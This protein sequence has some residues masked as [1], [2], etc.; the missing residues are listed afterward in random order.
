MD[1][2]VRI[3]RAAAAD[4]DDAARCFVQAFAR[5]PLIS[6][7]FAD[8]AAGRDTS[9]ERFF[10]LLLRARIALG[11][12]ALLAHDGERVVG[13]AMGYDTRRADWPEALQREW[14]DLEAQAPAI[15]ERFEAYEAI[16][17]MS[18][19]PAAHYYLGVL[20]VAPVARG[21][22][23]GSALL[24]AFCALSAQDPASSGV[25]LETANPDNL[26]FYGRHGFVER[27]SGRLGGGT[28]WCLFRV[29]PR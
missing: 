21:T 11:M 10:G 4:V 15:V 14:D 27:G 6:H 20:G 2:E 13:G 28:L 25:Y 1:H 29:D 12:P 18:E 8:S 26:G 3:V 5:D 7:F 23:T 9:A 24:R 19:P 22:G 17:A 16:A